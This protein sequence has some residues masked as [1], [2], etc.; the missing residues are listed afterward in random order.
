MTILGAPAQLYSY[1][2]HIMGWALRVL[3][4]VHNSAYHSFSALISTETYN[5]TNAYVIISTLS[6]S[7]IRIRR[8]G[9][10][11]RPI[12]DTS[13]FSTSNQCLHE[14]VRP[15]HCNGTMVVHKILLDHLLQI[16]KCD[17]VCGLVRDNVNEQL[18]LGIQLSVVSQVLK[19]DLVQHLHIKAPKVPSFTEISW[20]R[21]SRPESE[22]NL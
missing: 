15:R 13:A 10:P 12:M 7:Y 9:G 17:C 6:L 5:L 22:P 1:N 2:K 20:I 14:L 4:S 16:C 3:E 21:C 8:S 19:P 18:W 11:N